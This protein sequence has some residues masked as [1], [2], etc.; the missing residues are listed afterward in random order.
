MACRSSR[1]P[2][3]IED[4]YLRRLRPSSCPTD[5]EPRAWSLQPSLGDSGGA[6]RSAAPRPSPSTRSAPPDRRI[7]RGSSS[8]PSSAMPLVRSAV[9]QAAPLGQAPASARSPGGGQPLHRVP[10]QDR[11][12][13]HRGLAAARPA[14]DVAAEELA[15]SAGRAQARGGVRQRRPSCRR[16]AALTPEPALAVAARLRL[17]RPASK[18]GV[19]AAGACSRWRKPGLFTSSATCTDRP[20]ARGAEPLRSS[21]GTNATALLLARPGPARRVNLSVARETYVDASRQRSLGGRLQQPVGLP[22]VAAVARSAPRLPGIVPATADL[23]LD[24]LIGLASGSATA[25]PL[26]R[27]ALERLSRDEASAK[28]RLR[29]LW[30]GCVLSLEISDDQHTSA[31]RD[32]SV[33]MARTRGR[34]AVALTLSAPHAVLVSLR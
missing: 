8:R 13:W 20:A 33:E 32:S 5:A 9:Y 27:T 30:Q 22:R 3:H 12:A 6:T 4:H 18:A 15:E 34:S 29:W 28:E 14:E 31:C 1:S 21:H 2:A 16:A 7:A 19:A 26:S 17:L 10:T 25:V 11:R 24:A 23:L